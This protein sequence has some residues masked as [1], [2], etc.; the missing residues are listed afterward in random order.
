VIR[1]TDDQISAGTTA[2]CV[3][4]SAAF[5]DVVTGTAIE[6]IITSAT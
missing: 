1:A 2:G 6:S 4:T 5:Q 3:V